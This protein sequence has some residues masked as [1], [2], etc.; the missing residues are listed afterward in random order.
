M[1]GLFASPS[2]Q[3]AQT[4][5]SRLNSILLSRWSSLPHFVDVTWRS[6]M[7]LPLFCFLYL[8]QSKKS[9]LKATSHLFGKACLIPTG[10]HW[11]YIF[12]MVYFSWHSTPFFVYSTHPKASSYYLFNLL[13]SKMKR[14]GYQKMM[15]WS[16]QGGS[17]FP[18]G[19][20]SQYTHGTKKWVP[21][22]KYV[23]KG[24]CQDAGISH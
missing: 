22:K 4:S 13:I 17:N 8:E 1:P 7:A 19:A 9:F 14:W 15:I 16:L 21:I 6:T 3:Q 2:K 24:G 5:P 10:N 12:L 18:L 20:P 11:W 23:L